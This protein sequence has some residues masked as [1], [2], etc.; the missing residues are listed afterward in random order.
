M[1]RRPSD[2][3]SESSGEG[4]LEN[5]HPAAGSSDL[6]ATVRAKYLSLSRSDKKVA[7]IL[8]DSPATFIMRSVA[9]VAAEADV[10]EATVVRFGRTLGCQGFRDFKII[11]AQHLAARQA[12]LDAMTYAEEEAQGN[13]IDQICASATESLRGAVSNLNLEA[14]ERAAQMIKTAKRVA[15]FGLGGSSSVLAEELHF[16]LFRLGI[17]SAHYLDTYTQRMSAA[18]LESG[19][20]ALF[21]SSTGRPRSLIE[22]AEL[23]RHYGGKTIAITEKES[24]LAREV[25]ICLDVHL[26][27]TGV[28]LP[29]PNP[30]RYAQLL[31]IDCLACRVAVLLDERGEGF[32]ERARASIA[33]MHGIAPQQPVGD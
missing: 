29:Q 30:M 5:E 33:S 13:Y 2:T 24:H 12:K 28:P 19:D 11:L 32:L 15:V 26:S 18:T 20:L 23:C 21:V 9:D 6:L 4:S 8:L 25:D 27:Q 31:V 16:R 1:S 7:R 22:I 14:I 3:P 17:A 10:S